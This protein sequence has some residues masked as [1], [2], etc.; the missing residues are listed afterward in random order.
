MKKFYFALF[1]ATALTTTSSAQTSRDHIESLPKQITTEERMAPRVDNF[2]T[3]FS[4]EEGDTIWFDGFEDP[5]NWLFIPPSGDPDPTVNGWSIGN[6]SN[7]WWTNTAMNT[8]GNYARFVNGAPNVTPPTYI[9]DAPFIFQFTGTID[10]TDVPAPHLEFEQWGAR[11]ITHQAVQV[12]TDGGTT[13]VTAGSND[14]IEPLTADG[15]AAYANTQ[16]RRFNITQAVSGDPSNVMIRLFWDGLIN[17]PAMNYIEYGWFVDNIR[18]VEGFEDDLTLTFADFQPHWD[19]LVE[20]TWINL[21]YSVYPVSQVRE[22]YLTGRV[23]NNGSSAQSNVTMEVVIEQDG[24]EI[25]MLSSDP[26][27]LLPGEDSVFTITYT[28]PAEP[29]IYTLTFD[30]VSDGN[31]ACIEDKMGT[32]SFE[33]SDAV[34]ARDNGELEASGPNSFNGFGVDVGGGNGFY[35]SSQDEIHCIGAALHEDS[36][37]T[38]FFAGKIRVFNPPSGTL[39]VAESE[40]TSI[41]EEDAVLNTE[42]ESNFTWLNMANPFPVFD[43]DEYYVSVEYFSEEA[44]EDEGMIFIGVS[45]SSPDVSSFVWGPESTSNNT[46]DGC[47]TSSTYMVR[48]GMSAA[49]CS[50]ATSVEVPE[51]VTVNELYPNPTT[52]QTTLAYTLLES[53]DV[54]LML[55]DNMGRVVMQDDKPNQP[56]GEYRFDYDFDQLASGMYTFSIMIGDKAITKKLVIE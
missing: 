10:L 52:G 46:C 44:E 56:V 45:G 36:D 6:T 42:G 11:F 43:G 39:V 55:F 31:D 54:T 8:E 22:L 3:S 53:S 50:M 21:P 7:S 17:G 26:L 15:G 12:S 30:V 27:S 24:D 14:D 41:A 5:S 29:G 48:I 35:F 13:W 51:Q 18:I 16:T 2:Q 38:V 4:R 34:C 23:T 20:E 9:E 40:Y 33:I 19:Y 49:F 25:A 47:W 1:A 28:P 32:G 37:P